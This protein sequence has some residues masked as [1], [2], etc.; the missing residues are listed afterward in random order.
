MIANSQSILLAE[1]KRHAEIEL[2]SS[3]REAE[4]KATIALLQHGTNNTTRLDD[5][6]HDRQNEED[7]GRKNGFLAEDG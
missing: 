4:L 5:R 7:L 1:Q 2:A 3:L 6:Q